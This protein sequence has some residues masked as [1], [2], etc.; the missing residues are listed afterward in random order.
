[1]ASSS[2]PVPLS[3][4]QINYSQVAQW[5]QL[6]RQFGFDLRVSIPAILTDDMDPDEQTVSVQIA[7]QE[8]VRTPTGPEWTT[9]TPV[10]HV[11]IIIPR[12]GGTSI[13]LPLKE[14]DEGMLIFCDCCF[15][16][17][18][19]RGGVQNQI[20]DHRHEFWDCGFLPGMYSQPNAL[21]NYSTDSLQVRMDDGSAIVDVSTAKVKVMNHGGT[22]QKLVTD[23]FYQWFVTQL[24]PLIP[25]TSTPPPPPAN[26]ETTILE[27]Q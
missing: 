26:A 13:T 9:L 6:M 18:W 20:G 4:T 8:R 14:G 10:L 23:A 3:P 12:G 21:A 5:L 25:F 11:P 1:M 22:P 2:N 16:L 15:D 19:N 17:W 7:I 27:G 24:M